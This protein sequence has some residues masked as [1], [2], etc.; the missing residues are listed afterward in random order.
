[1]FKVGVKIL[2]L[3][4]LKN[5][6]L[7][8]LEEEYLKRISFPVAILEVKESK[9]EEFSKSSHLVLLDET[10]KQYTSAD[11]C[12]Y[13]QSKLSHITFLVGGPYGISPQI[14]KL[15]AEK[16]SLSQM[17]LPHA[18]ARLILIEQLYRANT[19]IKNH[20]YHH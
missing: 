18:L 14:S 13:L 19:I 4:K 11:F 16:I 9:V 15:A 2:V 8:R 12:K 17:T 10:G 5:I 1:M 20:P 6:Y 7:K 3:G